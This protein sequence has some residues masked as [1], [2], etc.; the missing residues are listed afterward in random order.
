MSNGHQL[1]SGSIIGLKPEFEG[2]YIALHKHTFP[3]VLERIHKSNISDYSIFLL[4]G[5][6]FSHII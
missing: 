4:N 1:V 3:G 6:L 2:Q 5:I